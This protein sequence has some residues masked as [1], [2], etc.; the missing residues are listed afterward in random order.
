MSRLVPYLSFVLSYLV[1]GMALSILS[2]F[3]SDGLLRL[4]LEIFS[5][6]VAAPMAILLAQRLG[7]LSVS[8]LL[9]AGVLCAASLYALTWGLFQ[10]QSVQ[11]GSSIPVWRLAQGG[12]WRYL[13]TLAAQAVAPAIWCLL[14]PRPNN[15]SKPKPLR[16]SA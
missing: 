6:V 12:G 4:F 1:L 13:L 9:V 10:W 7:Y 8:G 14:L 11:A 5:F 2:G 16:G 15:S 3:V